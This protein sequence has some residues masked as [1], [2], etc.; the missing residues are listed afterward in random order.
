MVKI[1]DIAKVMNLSEATVSNALTGKGRMNPKTR[2]AVLVCAR[3]MGY[4]FRKRNAALHKKPVIAITED[5]SE[6]SAAL[7]LSGITQKASELGISVPAYSLVLN[8]ADIQ[9]NPGPEQL[10]EK[11][12]SLLARLDFEVS[13]ILYISRYARKMDGILAHVEVP[14]LYVFGLCEDGTPFVHYDDRQGAKL[15]TETLLLEGRRRIAMIS[16]PIDSIGMYLRS[17]GYQYTLMEHQLPFDPDL[18]RLGDWTEQSGYTLTKELLSKHRDIDAIFAQ[19]DYIAFGA[20]KAVQ[21]MGLSIPKDLSIIGFD[22][23]KASELASPAL[24]TIEPPFE[25]MGKKALSQLLKLLGT[26]PDVSQTPDPM[27]PCSL[28]RRDSTFGK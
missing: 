15:A 1:S 8:S 19:N 27:L 13:G 21:E 5:F 16:G 25:E 20:A 2:E 12:L 11:V 24:T 28:I 17:L 9:Q 3:Q 4:S 23:I 26:E 7:I 22:N 18:I 10:N 6:R 14:A